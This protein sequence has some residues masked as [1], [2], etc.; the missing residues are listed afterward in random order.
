[1]KVFP[2][3]KRGQQGTIL[4]LALVTCL[5]IGITMSAYL[6]LATSQHRAVV[7]SESWNTAI[8]VAEAGLEEALSQLHLN[9]TNLSANNWLSSPN[10][11]TLANNIVLTGQQYYQA[12]TLENDRYIAAISGDAAPVITVQAYVKAPLTGGDI[13]RT[14]QVTTAG[15]ALFARA[16]VAKGNIEWSGNILSDSFDSQDPSYSTG[17]R[18]DILKRKD[19]GSV[20]SVEG[21]FTMGGGTI[22]GNANIGPSGSFSDGGGTVGDTGWVN[23]GN[24][25]VQSGHFSDDLNLSFPDVVPPFTSAAIPPAGWITNTSYS[26]NLA[27]V[28]SLISPFVY[29]GVV[30][31]N[32]VTSET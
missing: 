27:P 19:N 16:L 4:P 2:H 23:G 3:S 21:E 8:P 30:V 6:D 32:S 15:G 24:T 22:H 25:G 26:T 9:R 7:R 20:G 12:R 17:G 18:Y 29:V 31:R 11:L 13:V 10:G 14:I 5:I 1:M 28:V